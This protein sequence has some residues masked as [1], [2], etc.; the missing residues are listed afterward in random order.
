LYFLQKYTEKIFLPKAMSSKLKYWNYI[1][2]MI[3]R[4]FI[5]NS[6]IW[7]NYLTNSAYQDNFKN[8]VYSNTRPKI[9]SSNKS[10]LLSKSQKT[11]NK[12]KFFV[13]DTAF[14]TYLP[15]YL[16][17]WNKNYFV[18]PKSSVTDQASGYFFK[19][20]F[21][22]V[23]TKNKSFYFVNDLNLPIKKQNFPSTHR[24]KWLWY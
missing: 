17:Y 12:L 7:S 16:W 21:N 14:D 3:V 5:N 22:K 24:G 2:A 13:C 23:F 10:V 20:F 15:K 9:I 1:S 4:R 6:L 18:I 19:K 11:S 8:N